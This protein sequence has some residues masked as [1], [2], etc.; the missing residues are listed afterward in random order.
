LKRIEKPKP[1]SGDASRKKN[2]WKMKTNRDVKLKNKFKAIA[3]IAIASL[4]L[5]TAGRGTAQ[6]FTFLHSFTAFDQNSAK[7]DG[8]RNSPAFYFNHADYPS[9]SN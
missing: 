7:A 4:G 3:S 6:T 8:T 5:I 1:E 9:K 2:G